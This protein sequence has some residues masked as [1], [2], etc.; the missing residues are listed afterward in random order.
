MNKDA[1]VP[2]GSTCVTETQTALCTNGVLGAYDGTFTNEQCQVA[3]AATCDGTSF[4]LSATMAHGS[5]GNVDS[6]PST[7]V[8]F[9]TCNANKVAQTASCSDGVISGVDMT[10]K[11]LTCNEVPAAGCTSSGVSFSHEETKD[12]KTY[13]SATV[14]Y[15]QTCTELTS[16]YTC[17]NGSLTLNNGVQP[18]VNLTCSVTP[19]QDCGATK[20]NEYAS[21]TMNQDASVPFGSTCVTETQR[22]LCTDGTL[23]AYDGTFT[24]AQCQ[25]AAPATCDGSSYGLSST[26]A[27]N[28]TAVVN[29][30]P[31]SQVAYGTCEANKTQQT[32]SCT[33]GTISGVD[34]TGKALTC[35][36]AAQVTSATLAGLSEVYRV[37][38]LSDKSGSG[39]IFI[40]GVFTF[41]DG[42][43]YFNGSSYVTDSSRCKFIATWH[44][45][46]GYRAISNGIAPIPANAIYAR[47]LIQDSNNNL[48]VSLYAQGKSY[49]LKWTGTDWVSVGGKTEA[50]NGEI[51]SF[52][53]DSQ[54]NLYA[55]GAFTCVAG[56]N[57]AGNTCTS[58]ITFNNIA[59]LDKTSNTW[60]NLGLGFNNGVISIVIDNSDIIYAGGSFQCQGGGAYMLNT[61]P[62]TC[63]SGPLLS[64]IAKFQNGVWSSVGSGLNEYVSSITIDS[65]NNLIAVGGFMCDSSK[66]SSGMYPNTTCTGGVPSYNRIA[67]WSNNSWSRLGSGVYD[68]PHIVTVDNNDNIYV[69]GMS[70]LTVNSDDNMR[71]LKFSNGS[72]T[73]S[74]MGSFIPYINGLGIGSLLINNDNDIFVGGAIIALS[75][76]KP[77]Y[78]IAHWNGSTWNR[79]TEPSVDTQAPYISYGYNQLNL[80]ATVTDYTWSNAQISIPVIMDLVDLPKCKVISHNE[81]T[82]SVAAL[83]DNSLSSAFIDYTDCRDLFLSLSSSQTIDLGGSQYNYISL[84]AKDNHNNILHVGPNVIPAPPPPDPYQ[85]CLAMN[86]DDYIYCDCAVYGMCY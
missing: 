56:V 83:N 14:A 54:S 51:Y 23:G 45:L 72:Q 40:S 35:N 60:G 52:A 20:H 55:G 58:G 3:T 9:G 47:K 42:C 21:R 41:I 74:V 68:P 53:F 80:T 1:S 48:I 71:V 34:M 16:N 17:N 63:S 76:K 37:S 67:K 10:G 38:L 77:M 62:R 4:G 69:G 49:I 85:E 5:N 73:W 30:Y 50:F 61:N 15:N 33:N 24:N 32:A 79:F 44:P 8:A 22:A 66:S 81:P 7:Q 18:S 59:K 29:L 19:A 70:N 78:G 28:A 25:V 57:K 46:E 31:S 86:W 64:N 43:K 2:F 12:V 6:Y 27:H 75:D 13:S 11:S 65:A 82:P 39:R 84:L 26:M 36:E